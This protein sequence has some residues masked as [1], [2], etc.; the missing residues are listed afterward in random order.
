MK[1]KT[2]LAILLILSPVISLTAAPAPASAEAPYK[3]Y[4][5][6]EWN[7]SKAAPNSYLPA[8]AITGIDAGVGMFSEPQDLFVDKS[9]HIFIAD[10][11]NNRI[12]ELDDGFRKVAVIEKLELNGKTTALSGPTGVYVA[13]SGEMYIAD[14][15]NSRVLRVNP[16]GKADLVIGKP[17]HP[18]I[19]KDFVFKP[20]KVAADSAGR[21]YVLSEGQYYGLMQFDNQGKFTSYYGSNKV[22]VTPAVVLEAFWKS[23]LS[24][25]QRASMVKLLPIEYSNLDIGPDDFIY[26]TTIVSKNSSEQIKKLNPLG[27]NVLKGRNGDLRFGDREY[28][29]K[30]SVK[31]DTSFVDLSIDDQGFM[32]A[33]DRTRGHIFEYDQ[34]GNQTAVFG[35]IGNQKGTFLQPQAVSYL[36]GDIIVLDSG[37]SNITRFE[38]SEYGSMVRK[39]TAL[40]NQGLY[41]DAAVIWRQVAMRNGNSETAHFGI[42]KAMEKNEDYKGALSEYREGAERSGYSDSFAQIRIEAVRSH[43]PVIM[44]VVIALI[45]LY[46][47]WKLWRA[48]SRKQRKGA[49]TWE[50]PRHFKA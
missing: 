24:K 27:N 36:G 35:S 4:V 6:N 29:M 34:D 26:T 50:Y 47:V 31:V 19:P 1:I 25:E 18:L 37:K 49:K 14:K 11:G 15:G 20:I 43:L 41:E 39:A 8:A 38:L 32:A 12:V 33:L 17:D 42:A 40:Y 16:Q 28:T 45:A 9:G 21:I 30:N 7:Q 10:T 23:V 2:L 44:T 46:Y 3:A 5:Y 13:K 48:F 22:E